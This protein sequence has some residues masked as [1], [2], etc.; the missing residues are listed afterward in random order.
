MYSLKKYNDILKGANKKILNTVGKQGKLLRKFKKEDGFFDC[1]GMSQSNIYF[2]TRLHKF[3]RKL[4]VLK[5]STLTQSYFKSYF[6]LIKKVCKS[7]AD[8]FG[9]KK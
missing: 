6:K 5:N 4:P 7:N 1:V 9:E 2:K 3:L 8:V